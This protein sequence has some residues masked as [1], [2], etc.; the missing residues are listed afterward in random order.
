MRARAF[1]CGHARAR[2]CSSVCRCV[3]VCVL[4]K[5]STA[6]CRA[7]HGSS[8][9]VPVPS[10]CGVACVHAYV[11]VCI[12]CL[13]ETVASCVRVMVCG[14]VCVCPSVRAARTRACAYPC[15]RACVLNGCDC[16]CIHVQGRRRRTARSLGCHCISSWSAG[17]ALLYVCSS[18][19]HANAPCVRV[20]VG[21]SNTHP[22]S[23]C[24]LLA[25]HMCTCVVTRAC[26][27]TQRA[28]KHAMRGLCECRVHTP[29]AVS[30]C[31][32]LAFMCIS[33]KHTQARR[34]ASAL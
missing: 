14:Y 25:R 23:R 30:F 3:P 24:S 28:N 33:Q 27:H 31:S 29:H 17:T 6:R 7:S 13:A 10:V 5:L 21:L 34:Q 20:C 19:T 16:G 32:L 15:T 2:M 8:V 1:V 26:T 22:A 12:T 4:H 18:I 11:V 9:R